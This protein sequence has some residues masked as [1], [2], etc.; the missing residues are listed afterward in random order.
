MNKWA[1]VIIVGKQQ[2]KPI[3][4]RRGIY[5]DDTASLLLFTLGTACIL[6][7]LTTNQQLMIAARARKEAAAFMDD[8]KTHMP[9]KSSA[10]LTKKIVESSAR[11]VGLSK[12][13]KMRHLQ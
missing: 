9:M 7:S 4:V 1:I 5:Q 10:E 3:R 11:A 6:G 8:V 13:A 12:F 2:T